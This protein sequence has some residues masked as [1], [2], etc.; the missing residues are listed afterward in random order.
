MKCP[1]PECDR[2][3][4]FVAHRR[5]W[6]GKR[7]HRAK[8]CRD[9][10]VA[11]GPRQ[12]RQERSAATYPGWLFLRPIESPQPELAVVRVMARSKHDDSKSSK[13]LE[14]IPCFR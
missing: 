10:F 14:V 4:G 8:Q 11:E 1:N 7:Q 3:F 5:D 9:T 2:G 12:S 13:T 6:F